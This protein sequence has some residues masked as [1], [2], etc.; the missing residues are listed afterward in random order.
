MGVKYIENLKTRI[1]S[2]KEITSRIRNFIKC[3]LVSKIIAPINIDAYM[4]IFFIILL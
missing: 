2:K 3:D 4:N 1:F